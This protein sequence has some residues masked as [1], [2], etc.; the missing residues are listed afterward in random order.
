MITDL[1]GCG[2]L[3]SDPGIHSEDRAL[4]REDTNLGEEKGIYSFYVEQHPKCNKQLCMKT[5]LKRPD[6]ED[7]YEHII[8]EQYSYELNENIKIICDLCTRIK[9]ISYQQFKD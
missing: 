6:D 2:L 5:F 9:T 1:Q 3:L 7:E 8:D 4:F